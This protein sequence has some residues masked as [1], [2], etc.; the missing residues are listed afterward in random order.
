MKTVAPSGTKILRQDLRISAEKMEQLFEP[1]LSGM[2][3]CIKRVIHNVG[4]HIDV[5]YLVGG[6]GG[7]PYIYGK[8]LDEF[9]ISYKCIVPPN[10]E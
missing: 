7:C 1:V 4:G 9:G 8:L 6:F 5:I 10:P 3:S 2:L